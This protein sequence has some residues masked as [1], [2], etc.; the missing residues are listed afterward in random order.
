MKRKFISAMLF[1]AL[2][3]A[4]A[5]TFVGCAD[6]DDDIENLQGQITNNATTLD[7]LTKEKIQNVETEI[8]SLKAANKQLQEAL[9]KAKSEGTDADAATLAAAQKLVEDAQA[10]LQAALDA[11]N[12]DI[13][14]I[15]GK[16]SDLDAR[17]LAQ[18]G[19]LKSVESLLAADGKLT[20]AINDAQALAEKAYNLAEQTAATAE[21]NKQAIKDAAANLK[22]IKE[23][24]EG[25]INTLGEK[26]NEL[27]T[28][29]AKQN[30]DIT[31]QINSLKSQLDDAKNGISA[32]GNKITENE[33]KI[34]GIV[35]QLEELKNQI[36]ANKLAVERL[37][38]NYLSKLGDIVNEQGGLK[39][40]IEGLKNANEAIEGRLNTAES[41]LDTIDELIES[42]AK[43]SDVKNNIDE[44]RREIEA[45]IGKLNEEGKDDTVASLIAGI[46][47]N[48][49]TINGNI[50][51]IDGEITKINGLIDIL[52]TD[53]S[54]LITG[55]IVQD[56]SDFNAVYAQVAKYNVTPNDGKTYYVNN[57]SDQTSYFPYKGA[58]GVGEDGKRHISN[59]T[60]QQ[61]CGD[62]Y[63][64]I[65]PNTVS[66]EGQTLALLNSQD[67]ANPEY[68]L[69]K[70]VVS[71]KL[72][73]RAAAK[74][75][76]YKFSVYNE[77][78]NVSFVPEHVG[79]GKDEV[80]ALAATNQGLKG[81]DQK[82]IKDRRVYSKYELKFKPT[83]ITSY[84]RAVLSVAPISAG[85]LQP[86]AVETGVDKF[87]FE[88]LTGCQF[89]L[90][91]DHKV[92]AKYIECVG[93]KSASNQVDNTEK[94]NMNKNAGFQQI[95]KEA[96]INKG[97]FGASVSIN[98]LFNTITVNNAKNG[99]T[100][101][102][103]YYTWDYNG[104]ITK[105]QFKVIYTE[106]MYNENAISYEHT[107]TSASDQTTPGT[108][109]AFSH[110]L[111][112]T[113][114]NNV[115][116]DNVKTIQVVGSNIPN[117]TVYF[118]KADGAV[119]KTLNVLNGS[120]A[121]TT[122][123]T[124]SELNNIK[125]LSF[126]YNPTNVAP[127]DYKFTVKF[128]DRNGNVV[129][130]VDVKVTIKV[131]TTLADK[132]ER[133]HRVFAG[134]DVI[135]YAANNGTNAYANMSSAFVNVGQNL[136]ASS[137]TGRIFFAD[138]LSN[139]PTTPANENTQYKP[140]IANNAT[141]YTHKGNIFFDNQFVVPYVS[142]KNEH[143]YNLTVGAKYYGLNDYWTPQAKEGTTFNVKV[144]SPIYHAINFEQRPIEL[145]YPQ[146]LT[147]GDNVFS[148]TN[149]AD[150]S[151]TIKYLGT[152]RDAL[153]ASTKIEVSA[154][155]NILEV[156]STANNS[157]EL[158]LKGTAGVA[159]GQDFKLNFVVTDVFGKEKSYPITVTF[160]KN[161]RPEINHRR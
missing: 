44:L 17:L 118:N 127:G 155:D 104:A 69:T 77:N 73:T 48:I 65:N 149:P 27:S 144:V 138:A 84:N 108:S 98:E 64:T 16:I 12:G 71:N 13:T 42:L 87:C 111:S 109:T 63:A 35:N 120:S 32:N 38:S 129:T 30:A 139:Y 159:D 123:L 37:E 105:H 4:P 7:Q 11:V 160:K 75:G 132:I 133:I 51:R 80:Y 153:I 142:V 45:K 22:S 147:L 6:Y 99:Y 46:N 150:H 140:V 15:N 47:G 125:N 86:E 121:K 72:I 102:Y 96:S 81:K 9:D 126:K 68:K 82:D 157:F 154:A 135:L 54:N 119:V 91:A 100:Y 61:Y 34:S 56:Y 40:S 93:A 83:N 122:T 8:E 134:D 106:A 95:L 156:T 62:V 53:L 26:V 161:T 107:P 60:V 76:L 10:Q 25:Q 28:K 128:Y 131:P 88:K 5:T 14:G 145:S 112:M 130:S 103:D 41:R 20:L 97:A 1:G 158:K 90:V 92:Y 136:T 94:A 114:K 43:S 124:T 110:T 57:A 113:S 23:S 117:M 49:T 151:Q 24:L 70:A 146:V 2:L 137:G 19:R 52:F 58:P 116:K 148:A 79:D 21:A 55:L 29:L 78:Q 101:T 89:N 31:A 152:N 143:V 59:Y 74:N 36:A 141:C 67:V 18:D 3:I 39:T 85:T 115:W 33:Q 50:E 66:F